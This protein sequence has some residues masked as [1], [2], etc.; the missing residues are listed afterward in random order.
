MLADPK[1]QAFVENFSQQWLQTRAILDIPDQLSGNHGPGDPRY[2]AAS[3][4]RRPAQS[5]ATLTARGFRRGGRGLPVYTGTEL[6][7]EVRNAM[8]QEV[9]AYF[10]YVV[11]EDRSVLEFLKSNYTFVNAALAPV[12]GLPTVTGLEMRK[13]ELR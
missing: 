4:A 2:S 1:A 12:Y 5:R 10:G 7:P 8:K 6:I 13:V 11:R 9:D 3:C